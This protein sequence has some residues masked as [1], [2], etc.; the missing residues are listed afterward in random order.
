MSLAKLLEHLETKLDHYL[1]DKIKEDIPEDDTVVCKKRDIALLCEYLKRIVH[2]PVCSYPDCSTIQ[3]IIC[4]YCGQKCCSNHYT[5]YHHISCAGGCGE[6]ECCRDD[7]SDVSEW[8][9][10]ADGKFTCHECTIRTALERKR[11]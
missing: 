9:R 4:D 2:I 3:E 6:R 10:N 7:S 8:K 5:E 11:G 1:V